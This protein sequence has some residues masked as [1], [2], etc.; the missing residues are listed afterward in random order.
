MLIHWPVS[1]VVTHVLCRLYAMLGVFSSSSGDCVSFFILR[2]NNN[3][4]GVRVM[5]PDKGLWQY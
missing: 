1:A 2:C 5:T 4:D 3:G